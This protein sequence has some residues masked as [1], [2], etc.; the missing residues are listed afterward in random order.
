MAEE[1]KIPGQGSGSTDVVEEKKDDL[2]GKGKDKGKGWDKKTKFR[3]FKEKKDNTKYHYNDPSWYGSGQPLIDACNLAYANPLGIGFPIHTFLSNYATKL[4]Q[5]YKLPGIMAIGIQPLLNASDGSSTAAIQDA[6]RKMYAFIRH[7]NAGAKNYERADLMMY[8]GAVADL[9]A[10]IAWASLAYGG[11]FTYQRKNTY[12]GRLVVEALGFDYDDLLGNLSD[13]RA[14]INTKI[15]ILNTLYIPNSFKYL[16]RKINLFSH[17]IKDSDDPKGCVYVFR[18]ESFFKWDGSSYKT[19]TALTWVNTPLND[20]AEYTDEASLFNR[21]LTLDDFKDLANLLFDAITDDE[22]AGII[23]GDILKAY[24]EKGLKKLS[25]IPSDF[26][27]TP[28]YD[29]EA[30]EVINNLTFVGTPTM[31]EGGRQDRD[32]DPSSTDVATI[33]ACHNLGVHQYENKIVSDPYFGFR[34]LTTINDNFDKAGSAYYGPIF[35]IHSKPSPEMTMVVS[36]LKA[37]T[38][39]EKASRAGGTYDHYYRL[40]NAGTEVATRYRIYTTETGLA[41][42]VIVG[43]G[44]Y[45]GNSTNNTKAISLLETFDWHPIIYSKVSDVSSIDVSAI[46]YEFDDYTVAYPETM[47]KMNRTALFALFDLLSSM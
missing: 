8:Y 4:T 42:E 37:T 10:L 31:P 32:L 13:F 20:D 36:R 39:Y 40:L 33:N 16:D 34:N 23:S 2:A 19:G 6:A 7:M 22:D 14:F 41:N 25:L 24:G 18:P 46:H 44:V 12:Y 38:Y 11:C 5:M 43:N 21:A 3:K 17:I 35:S 29:I 1:K 28:T 15:Q 45:R 9:Y 47:D 26:S 30:L 27:I